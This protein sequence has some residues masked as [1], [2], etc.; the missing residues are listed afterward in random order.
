MVDVCAATCRVIHALQGCYTNNVSERGAFALAE[1]M[2][3]SSCVTELMLVSWGRGREGWEGGQAVG[4]RLCGR[5]LE[6]VRAGSLRWWGC[7]GCVQEVMLFVLRHF[8]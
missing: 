5:M 7:G 1:A 3:S 6:L 8:F 2:K 4:V